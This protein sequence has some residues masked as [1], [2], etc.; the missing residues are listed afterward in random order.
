MAARDPNMLPRAERDRSRALN[1]IDVVE[2]RSRAGL[3]RVAQVECESCALGRY[4]GAKRAAGMRG[5]V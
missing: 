3:R 1:L 2:C 4:R 5:G